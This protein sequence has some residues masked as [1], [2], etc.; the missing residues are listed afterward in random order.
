GFLYVPST[1]LLLCR[2]SKAGLTGLTV[3]KMLPLPSHFSMAC[4]A[5]FKSLK[6]PTWVGFLPPSKTQTSVTPPAS[7]CPSADRNACSAVLID[8]CVAFV[9]VVLLIVLAPVNRHTSPGPALC[10]RLKG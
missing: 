7:A 3:T 5:F 9:P 6:Y 2:A 4:A 1:S 10:L 8:D